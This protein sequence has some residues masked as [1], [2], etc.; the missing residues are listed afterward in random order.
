V[1]FDW[2]LPVIFSPSV[3]FNP[4]YRKSNLIIFQYLDSLFTDD[5]DSTTSSTDNNGH[6]S[7]SGYGLNDRNGNHG[8]EFFKISF[9]QWIIFCYFR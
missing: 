2:P 6:H 5:K 3:Y 9:K 4:I 8:R 7:D 1:E